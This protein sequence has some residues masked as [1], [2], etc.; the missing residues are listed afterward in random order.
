MLSRSIL[1]LPRLFLGVIFARAAYGK[2]TAPAPGFKVILG[3]FLQQ[4]LPHASP[5]YQSFAHAVV[6]PNLGLVAI[7][8]MTGELFVAVGML[9][10]IT[11]RL[12]SV[13]AVCLLLNYMLAKGMNLWTPASNDAADIILAIIVGIGAAG[14]VW[15]LDRILAERWPRIPLW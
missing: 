4:L 5:L 1:V 10:G 7:L 12:A 14:R 2:F 3:G 11:T 15:G 9:F 8:V 6:L 13:V